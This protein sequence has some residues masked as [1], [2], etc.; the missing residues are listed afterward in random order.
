MLNN[1]NVWCDILRCR[2]CCVVKMS[3]NCFVCE[4]RVIASSPGISKVE[5]K[6]IISLKK[7]SQERCDGKI[8][9]LAKAGSLFVHTLCRTNFTRTQS[10]AALK[11]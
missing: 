10:I 7:A 6:G 5:E 4:E 1:Y 3:S 2:E 11:K 9:Q 8:S